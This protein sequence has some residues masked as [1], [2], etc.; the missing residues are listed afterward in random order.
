MLAISSAGE[1]SVSKNLDSEADMR[2]THVRPELVPAENPQDREESMRKLISRRN[3]IRSVAAA[4]SATIIGLS[5]RAI[6]PAEAQTQQFRDFPKLDGELLLDDASRQAIDGDASNIF[7]RIPAAVLKPGS[8]Q[9]IVEMVGFANRHALKV[10]IKGN[11][12][13]TYGQSQ[14]EG[15]IVIDSDR[16]SVV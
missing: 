8:V 1:P 6:R 9:D 14:A 3:F 16:K 10:A 5:P 2:R 15:G 12:H 13:S 7:H 11:G 4:S